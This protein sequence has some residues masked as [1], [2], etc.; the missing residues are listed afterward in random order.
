M[1]KISYMAGIGANESAQ[2]ADGVKPAA[3]IPYLSLTKGEMA[4][5]LMLEQARILAGYYGAPKYK[6]AA[7][8]LE[9]AL[10]NGVHGTAPYFGAL[11]PDLYGVARAINQ[12]RRQSAPASGG[13]VLGR[14]SITGGIGETIVPYDQRYNECMKSGQ[15]GGALSTQAQCQKRLKIEKILNDGLEKCG[16]YLSYGF[17]PSKG[18]DGLPPTAFSKL[19]SQLIAIQDVARVAKV[20]QTLIGQWLNVGMMRNNATAPGVSKPYGWVDT[21]AILTATPESAQ[22]QIVTLFNTSASKWTSPTSEALT[23]QKF[24]A[25]IR[26]YKGSAAVGFDPAT[27]IAII[28]A[29]A[30][31]IG[32]ISEFAKQM[33]VEQADAFSQVNGFGT[34]A[35][36]PE[37]GDYDGD[38]ILDS[39]EGGSGISTPLLL[40][41]GALALLA[42]K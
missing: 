42:L 1:T 12:A 9:N 7:T 29:I 40:G 24:T 35:L 17:L 41:A 3:F 36:G 5:S 20:E 16:Q 25:I 32:G 21:N 27:T 37:E 2:R 39:Q 31:L 15:Y 34:K 19:R 10:T 26:K 23:G 18:V 4:L 8:M 28:T 38:G 30:A 14:K 33:R 22:N 13:L 11:E 6:E